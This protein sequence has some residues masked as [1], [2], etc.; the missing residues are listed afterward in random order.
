MGK[1]NLKRND[2][3]EIV[4]VSI[5]EQET[6]IS[7]EKLELQISELESIL[8]ELK[9]NLEEVKTFEVNN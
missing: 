1:L 2:N 7:S 4:V 3:N 9:S 8:A 6:P 5:V